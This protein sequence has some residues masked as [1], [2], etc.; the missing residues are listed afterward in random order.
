M[1]GELALKKAGVAGLQ[2]S[3]VIGANMQLEQRL[4]AAL[5]VRHALK[6]GRSTHLMYELLVCRRGL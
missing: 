1:E 2:G 6:N 4:P 3:G 5:W